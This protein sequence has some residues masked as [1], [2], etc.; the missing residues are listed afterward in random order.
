V[1]DEEYLTIEEAAA[2]LK[3]ARATIFKL[4][5]DHDIVRYQVPGVR[6]VYI[7]RADMLELRKPIPR[8]RPTRIP[9]PDK[10]QASKWAA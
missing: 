10:E 3:V 6:K 4:L 7:K 5:R 1:D 9:R 8:V 2:E